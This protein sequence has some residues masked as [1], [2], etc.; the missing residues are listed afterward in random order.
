MTGR[1]HDNPELQ[2]QPLAAT[3]T[4]PMPEPRARAG[5]YPADAAV[6]GH[7]LRVFRAGDAAGTVDMAAVHLRDLRRG[8]RGAVLVRYQYR[9]RAR[10]GLVETA[11]GITRAGECTDCRQG[12]RRAAVR[13]DDRGVDECARR[14]PGRR[15]AGYRPVAGTGSRAD[16]RHA[17]VFAD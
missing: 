9:H 15:A 10:P 7:V 16:R 3:D 17:A 5:I 11:A 2:S 14:R 6:P 1:P 4:G 12:S 8:R 13:A